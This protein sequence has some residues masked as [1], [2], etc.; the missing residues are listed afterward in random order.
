MFCKISV[1]LARYKILVFL[2]AKDEQCY[3]AVKE[4]RAL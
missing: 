1:K 3:S 2:A 4:K